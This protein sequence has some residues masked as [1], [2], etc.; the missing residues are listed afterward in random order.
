MEVLI[1]KISYFLMI[2]Y[3]NKLFCFIEEIKKIKED[4]VFQIDF[5]NYQIMIKE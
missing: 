3:R 2:R 5:M 1:F 4:C